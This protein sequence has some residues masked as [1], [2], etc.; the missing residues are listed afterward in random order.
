VGARPRAQRRR[1]T[2]AEIQLGSFLFTSAVKAKG[3]I[4]DRSISSRAVDSFQTDYSNTESIQNT[5]ADSVN[6][7]HIGEHRQWTEF[8]VK[9]ETLRVDFDIG[10]CPV[11]KSVVVIVAFGGIAVFA[12]DTRVHRAPLRVVVVGGSANR[13]G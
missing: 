11:A 3:S 6:G 9:G 7:A 5:S 13:R 2:H 4:T 10:F 1:N 8:E 12:A